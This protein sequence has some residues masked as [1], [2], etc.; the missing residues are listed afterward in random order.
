MNC[1]NVR[2]WHIPAIRA[3]ALTRLLVGFKRGWLIFEAVFEVM[4]IGTMAP[5]TENVCELRCTSG[6]SPRATKG[7]D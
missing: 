4:R 6:R 7:T 2:S 1:R 3:G 5:P